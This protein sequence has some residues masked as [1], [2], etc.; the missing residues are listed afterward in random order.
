VNSKKLIVVAIRGQCYRNNL[1]ALTIFLNLYMMV[2]MEHTKIYIVLLRI[3]TYHSLLP[4]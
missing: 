3:E 4:G 2:F 1:N